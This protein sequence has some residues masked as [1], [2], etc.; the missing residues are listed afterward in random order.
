MNHILDVTLSGTKLQLHSARA[1]FWPDRET[2]FVADTHFGKEATFRRHGIPVPRGSTDG[3]LRSLSTLISDVNAVR[4]VVLGDLFHARSS[5]SRDV[6]ESMDVFFRKHASL[7]ITLVRG[8]H[9][10]HVGQL[11]PA[12]PIDVVEPGIRMG[13][14]TLTHEP[15]A[16]TSDSTLVLCGHIHPGI[17]IRIATQSLGRMPCF[18]M[19]NRCLVLPA[20]G[21]FT[22]LH[23]VKPKKDSRV[24]IVADDEIVEHVV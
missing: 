19:D 17:N 1:V 15:S 16:P 4:L 22:G 2:L 9:D 12:W 21:Q 6:C 3:T 8:N 5:L 11:P 20:F 10:A 13:A 18:W 14:F 24:W 23:C 7:N